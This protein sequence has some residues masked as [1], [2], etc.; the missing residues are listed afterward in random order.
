MKDG[1]EIER[2]IDNLYGDMEMSGESSR[3][4]SIAR[5]KIDALEWVKG[6]G[7]DLVDIETIWSTPIT[8]DNIKAMIEKIK[9]SKDEIVEYSRF[10]DANWLQIDGQVETLEWVLRGE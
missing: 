10:G 9:R 6:G 8:E 4:E 3:G 5:H 1:H 2:R 7:D